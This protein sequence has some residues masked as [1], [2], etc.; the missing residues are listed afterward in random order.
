MII[1]LPLKIAPSVILSPTMTQKC[2]AANVLT[3]KM[4]L[5]PY[6]IDQYK[7]KGIFVIN[8]FLNLLEHFGNQFATLRGKNGCV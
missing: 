5:W 2:N 6:L 3:F 1:F 4:M 8:Q 7:Y